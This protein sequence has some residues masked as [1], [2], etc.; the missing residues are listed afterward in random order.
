MDR[1]PLLV[2]N[3]LRKSFKEGIFT[4][5]IM[6]RLEAD[7]Q[8]SR[9]A[10][11]G[12]IGPNGAGKSTL[13]GL[14]A[15]KIAP[16]S[17]RV[18]CSGENIQRIKYKERKYVVSHRYANYESRK[19]EKSLPNFLLKSTKVPDPKIYLYDE[20]DMDDG[21]IGLVINYFRKLRKNGRLVIFSVHPSNFFHLEIFQRICDHYIFVNNGS[22]THLSDYASLTKHGEMQNY[23]SQIDEFQT[24]P[25]NVSLKN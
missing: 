24:A 18:I 13:F 21:Y 1:K 8:F 9:P 7:F 14:L 25:S 20:V 6:F 19:I 15:G 3:N 10:I 5:R 17:G 12:V 23:I 22:L 11:V 16:T 4:K 2:A